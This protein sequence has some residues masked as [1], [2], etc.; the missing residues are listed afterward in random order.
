MAAM[1]NIAE[2]LILIFT[3]M[4]SDR[5]L[6]KQV[7]SATGIRKTCISIGLFGF[8]FCIS[9]V[10]VSGCQRAATVLL[11]VLALGLSGFSFASAAVVPVDMSP[12]FAGRVNSKVYTDVL[13]HFMITSLEDQF[14]EDLDF[15]QDFFAFRHIS[16]II[17]AWIKNNATK[18]L[19]RL[20]P[21]HRI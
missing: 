18:L 16:K 11:M 5:L 9:L 12:R 7:F 13:E 14:E 4:I 19:L 3:S 10:T 8:A 20:S 2:A 6:K 15:Q 21:V 1:P 17:T